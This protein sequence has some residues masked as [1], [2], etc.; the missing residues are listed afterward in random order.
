MIWLWM[1]TAWNLTFTREPEGGS[2]QIGVIGTLGATAMYDEMTTMRL[3]MPLLTIATAV[4]NDF[5]NA[6]LDCHNWFMN[7]LSMTDD[8]SNYLCTTSKNFTWTDPMQTAVAI[9]NTYLY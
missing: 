5:N 2:Y 4:E 9:S 7:K 3:E 1:Q 8:Q 6:G